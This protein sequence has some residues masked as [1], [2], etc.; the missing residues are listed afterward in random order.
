MPLPFYVWFDEDFV[1]FT[2]ERRSMKYLLV[3]YLLIEGSWVRGDTMEGWASIA[4]DS[5]ALCIE[6]KVAAEGFQRELKEQNPGAYEKRF[7]CEPQ[8]ENSDG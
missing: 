1:D 5:E 8:I 3:V 6:R 2:G 4:Y 7:D